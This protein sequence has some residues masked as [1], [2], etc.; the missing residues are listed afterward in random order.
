MKATTLTKETIMDVGVADRGFPDFAVG[1]TIRVAQIVREG[2]KERIQ[3]FEGDI[4]AFHNHGIATTF[5]VRKIGANSIGVEKIFPYH[6]PMIKDITIVKKGLVRRA[7]L[8]Y[9]RDR[10]G[11]SAR[12]K[13]KVLTKEEKLK[14]AAKKAARKKASV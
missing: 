4:L 2:T 14:A 6:S 12:I 1:D 3:M 10:V 8:Y 13:E 5:V 7:K 11:K 9:I